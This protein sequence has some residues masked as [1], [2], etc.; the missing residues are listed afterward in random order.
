VKADGFGLPP[1]WERIAQ[2][3]VNTAGRKLLLSDSDR[4]DIEGVI[5]IT[6]DDELR[7]GLALVWD[8]SDPEGAVARLADDL[9]EHSLDEEVW[10]GWP[11]CPGHSHPL[12]S[13]VHEGVAVWICPARG[14]VVAAIGSLG[15]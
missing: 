4:D 3:L 14:D 9:R 5:E 2:D 13:G 15:R 12:E 10:G 11:I 7:G 6:L 1:G 8:P